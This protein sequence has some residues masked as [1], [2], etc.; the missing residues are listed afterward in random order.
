MKQAMREVCVL[1]PNR[2]GTAR[3]VVLHNK[4]ALSLC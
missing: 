2:V 3:M 4:V 1:K